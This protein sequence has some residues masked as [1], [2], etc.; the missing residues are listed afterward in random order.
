MFSTTYPNI[1]IDTIMPTT[2]TT[3]T[4]TYAIPLSPYSST[5]PTWQYQ[6]SNEGDTSAADEY[7]HSALSNYFSG[8][9]ATFKQEDDGFS[10]TKIFPPSDCYDV[11]NNNDDDDEGSTTGSYID[12]FYAEENPLPDYD[13]S[14]TTTEA[15]TDMEKLPLHPRQQKKK[16]SFAKQPYS[17][18][19]RM[20]A[21]IQGS[22]LDISPSTARM[23]GARAA[24]SLEGGWRSVR[25]V[26][27]ILLVVLLGTWTGQTV[28][29]YTDNDV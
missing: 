27:S 22:E 13:D 14:E 26:M 20:V 24:H 9:N 11:F 19:Q 4:G 10:Q 15:E 25:V 3:P 12:E 18:L 6:P 5:T 2:P 7:Y 23:F 17:L 29:G 21:D 16:Q 1:P 8:S 28:H